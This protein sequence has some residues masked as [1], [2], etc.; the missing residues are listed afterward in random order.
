LGTS[1]R[2]CQILVEGE[3]WLPPFFFSF[4][5]VFFPLIAAPYLFSS[6]GKKNVLFCFVVFVTLVDANPKKNKD[7][8]KRGAC[9]N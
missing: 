5:D 7:Y 9:F 3:F 4:D 1:G 2:H 8:W 6:V